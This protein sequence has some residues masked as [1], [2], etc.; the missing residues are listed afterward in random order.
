MNARSGYVRRLPSGRYQ[1]RIT[2]LDRTTGTIK[3]RKRTCDTKPQAVEELPKLLREIAL[4]MTGVRRPLTLHA[5]LTHFETHHVHA[6]EYRDGKK[7]S[8]YKSPGEVRYLLGVLRTKVADVPLECV[9]YDTCAKLKADLLGDRIQKA[10]SKEGKEK[11]PLVPRSLSN[12]NRILAQLRTV[13]VIAARRE[14]IRSNPFAMGPQLISL[15]NEKR[16]DRILSRKEEAALMKACAC[17]E[18]WNLRLGITLAIETGMREGEM[19]KLEWPDVDLKKGIIRVRAI[20]CK[21]NIDR[22]IGISSAARFALEELKR[23]GPYARVLCRVSHYKVCWTTACREAGLVGEKKI[24]FRD[25]RHTYGTRQIQAGT[26][27]AELAKLMGHS[28]V[29]MTMRYVNVDEESAI[30]AAERANKL[31]AA[32]EK[33]QRRRAS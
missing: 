22:I 1:A 16:R 31:T 29:N 18:R 20:N 9:T 26:P 12:V 2:Y 8:G 17:D 33:K 15:A 5:L 21:T 23:Y 24:Q 10:R 28:D 11:T 4:G 6:A 30:E 19:L 32:I 7:V 13:L 25:L 3:E 14:W 27:V